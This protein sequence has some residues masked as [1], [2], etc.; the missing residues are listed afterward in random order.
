M[1]TGAR[2][3]AGTPAS[4][5]SLSRSNM[6]LLLLLLLSGGV[7]VVVVEVEVDETYGWQPTEASLRALGRTARL[8]ALGEVAACGI[9]KP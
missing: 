2:W 1:V 7:V 6:L 8:R 4:D 3:A 5:R 9:K